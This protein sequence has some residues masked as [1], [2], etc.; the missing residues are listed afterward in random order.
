MRWIIGLTIVTV[1]IAIYAVWL[2]P[3]MR[4][5]TWGKKILDKV[6]PIERVLWK[7]SETILLART[8]MA[9]GGL[10]LILTFL[11]Q[12][13]VEPILLFLPAEY[14]VYVRAA[15]LLI[16]SI[17]SMLGAVDEKLRRDTT[18]P[19]E[20]VAMRTDAPEEVKIAAAKAEVAN[21]IAVAKVEEKK[22]A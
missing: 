14:H 15:V 19:L 1:L 16:P 6:E 12:I 7:N 4:V 8:K 13:S 3:L 2:R 20:I 9:V 18:K 11:G 10:I 22:A 5:T 17:L 21:A